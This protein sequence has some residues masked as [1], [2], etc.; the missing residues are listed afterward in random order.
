MSSED[1]KR[2][3]ILVGFFLIVF[4]VFFF[5][6]WQPKH[7]ELG[8]LQVRLRDKE[9]RLQQLK[10][11]AEDWP[12][13]ITRDM[14]AKYEVQ[15]EHLWSLIPSEEEIA[16]LLDEIQTQARASNLEIVAMTRTASARGVMNAAPA[17][18]P[19]APTPGEGESGGELEYVRVPYEISLGGAYFGLIGFLR[20]LEDSERLVTVTMIEVQSGLGEHPVNVV[21]R[22]NIFYSKAGVGT[23]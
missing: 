15:L 4:L 20:R 17:A 11:E 16:M 7:A 5:L 8:Q 12:D 10:E 1:I 22:F 14:L 2:L 13:T 21:V 6:F 23:G 3:L 18:R 9:V 19:G